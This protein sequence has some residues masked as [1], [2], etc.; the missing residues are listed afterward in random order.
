MKLMEDFKA[1]NNVPFL[2]FTQPNLR[3]HVNAI[4]RGE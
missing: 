4:H 1:D 2:Q 3:N